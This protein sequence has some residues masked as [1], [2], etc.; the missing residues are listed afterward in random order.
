MAR[1]TQTTVLVTQ[2]KEVSRVPIADGNK[3]VYITLPKQIVEK[4]EE[5]AA[6]QMRSLSSMTALMVVKGL[7]AEKKLKDNGDRNGGS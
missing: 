1:M 3:R 7:E 6:E 2:M 5:M 4:L